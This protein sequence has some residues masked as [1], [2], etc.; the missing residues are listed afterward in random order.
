[1]SNKPEFLEYIDEAN[2]LEAELSMMAR[3][4]KAAADLDHIDKDTINGLGIF[5]SEIVLKKKILRHVYF[6]GPL[7]EEAGDRLIEAELARLG[8]SQTHRLAT[9]KVRPLHA[10]D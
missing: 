9:D 10:E 3:L 6:R 2:R 5:I 4:L 1:M 8:C 7:P